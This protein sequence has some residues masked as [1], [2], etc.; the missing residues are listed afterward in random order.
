MSK[1]LEKNSRIGIHL[2]AKFNTSSFTDVISLC[3]KFSVRFDKL[4]LF[5]NSKC[6]DIS[7]R[8]FSCGFLEVKWIF[9]PVFK[10]F[11]QSKQ[12]IL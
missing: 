8:K 4:E 6:D 3:D 9:S 5:V 7:L 12:D 1:N 10:V 11:K 2:P